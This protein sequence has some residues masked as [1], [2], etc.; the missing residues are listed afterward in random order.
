MAC[1]ARDERICLRNSGMMAMRTRMVSSTMDRT[2]AMP[3]PEDI[4]SN[5]RRSWIQTHT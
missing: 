1:I 4:P 2:H 3:E 5:T